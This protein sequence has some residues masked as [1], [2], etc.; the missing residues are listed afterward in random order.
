MQAAS[1]RQHSLTAPRL[2]PSCRYTSCGPG[3]PVQ[4]GQGAWTASAT[5]W[6]QWC[7]EAARHFGLPRRAIEGLAW[8]A[9]ITDEPVLPFCPSTRRK[10]Y[11]GSL[12]SFCVLL[13]RTCMRKEWYRKA[14]FKLCG[15]T[16]L[17]LVSVARSCVSDY[18]SLV[19]SQTEVLDAPSTSS[20]EE[21]VPG[22]L[23]WAKLSR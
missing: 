19:M 3:H 12:L 18:S 20:K 4:K 13:S 7:H 23:C 10:A 1:K 15:P 9:A 11:I 22:A 14:A 5:S 8:L 21:L 6:R 2:Q 17:R 16:R